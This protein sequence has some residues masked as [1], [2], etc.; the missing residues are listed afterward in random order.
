MDEEPRITKKYLRD[1][2][3]KHKL[4]LTPELNDKLYLHYKGFPQI[5]NLEEYTGV[6]ALY[7]EGNGL[8]R[9][10]GLEAL[11]QLRNL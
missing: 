6:R 5:E 10:E 1:H 7:L 11:V 2:C 8:R 9:I 3:K 4:Y